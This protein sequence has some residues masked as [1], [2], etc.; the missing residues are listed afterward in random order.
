VVGA[1]LGG[2]MSVGGLMSCPSATRYGSVPRAC[3]SS[4]QYPDHAKVTLVS[5][6][7]F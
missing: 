1:L 3:W 7:N 2:L 5:F 6:G 4:A